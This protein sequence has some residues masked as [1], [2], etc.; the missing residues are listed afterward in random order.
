MRSREERWAALVS[1]L[2]AVLLL[3]L[4]SRCSPLYPTN[5]WGEANAFFTVGRGMLAGKLPYR[6]FALNAGPLVFALH[7]LAAWISPGSFLGVWLLEIAALAAAL[8]IAWKAAVRVGGRKALSMGCAALAGLL[9]VSSRAF[10][11]GDTVEEFALPFQL[12]ALCDLL[13]Y[14]DDPKRSMSL[15]RMLLHGVLAGCVFWMK[16]ALCGVHLAFIAVIAVD[17]LA[18]AGGVQ[19]AVRLC[20]AFALGLALTLIPWLIYFGANAALA[21]FFSVYFYRN[22]KA[23]VENARPLWYALVGL[24]SGVL[25]NPAAALMLLCGAMYLLLH[26]VRR[27]WRATHTAVTVAFACAAVLAYW[28][29]T[30]YAYSPMAVAAF[31]LLSAGP[32]A[33]LAERL[34]SR[35]RA[36]GGMLAVAAAVCVLFNCL[37]N[38]NLPYIGYPAEELPQ[39]KFAQIMAENGGG[40]MLTYDVPDSG[41]YLAAD[42]LPEHASFADCPAWFVSDAAC[43]GLEM[44]YEI[45]KWNGVEW[46]ISRGSPPYYGFYGL[47]AEASSPYDRS[48][49]A[50][51]DPYRYY[52]FRRAQ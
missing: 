47:V 29:G 37:T 28:E 49:G 27:K 12:W 9:L 2:L 32:L 42:Q 22:W 26:L 5:N 17:A 13:R 6:D 8:F 7:A 41:F 33:R 16:F 48:V 34:W 52:L 25:R 46:V 15:R 51:G 11:S 35:R 40:S 19:R 38:G 4:F 36:W 21:E 24:G 31:L 43:E 1:V 50:R 45:L 39:Q 20:C 23:L 30:R 3:L 44:Q 14:M 18:R 10:V